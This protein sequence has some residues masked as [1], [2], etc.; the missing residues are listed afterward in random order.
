[1]KGVI[2][3][4]RRASRRT[5]T[6]PS[7]RPVA[8]RAALRHLVH[9]ALRCDDL[10]NVGLCPDA[11]DD[12][13]RCEHCP[14]DQLMRRAVVRVELLLRRALDL[15]VALKLRFRLGLDEI[16][17]DDFYAIAVTDDEREPPDRER[18]AERAVQ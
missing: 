4:L 15:R 18:L 5:E 13:G 8:R 16:R 14:L 3:A 17:T 7:E 6:Q 10:C 12:G 11:P 2:D 9:C 1:V